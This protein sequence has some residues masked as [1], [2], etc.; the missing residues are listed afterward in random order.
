MWPADQ[1]NNSELIKI[2]IKM[3][4]STLLRRSALYASLFTTGHV[5]M[6]NDASEKDSVVGIHHDQASKDKLKAKF[7]SVSNT[8]FV[9]LETNKAFVGSKVYE[10]LY[11]V[12]T[13]LKIIGIA[14]SNETTAVCALPFLP[15]AFPAK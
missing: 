11:G 15:Y 6:S 10:P 7:P 9:P 3:A 13:S 5:V 14:K 1:R 12:N 8:D 4:T 2:I